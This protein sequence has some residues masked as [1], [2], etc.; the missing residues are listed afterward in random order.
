M[1]NIFFFFIF[2]KAAEI[3]KT[4]KST[5]AMAE[6]LRKY[7]LDNGSMDNISVMVIKLN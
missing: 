3:I 6:A 1:K 5:Q 2:K 4:K 7:A